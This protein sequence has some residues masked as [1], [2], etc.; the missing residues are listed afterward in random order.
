MTGEDP[1]AEYKN[2]PMVIRAL[3][4]KQLPIRPKEFAPHTLRGDERW[5]LLLDCWNLTP[6]L[7][8]R[9]SEVLDAVS[10]NFLSSGAE[11]VNENDS[12]LYVSDERTSLGL[13][14]VIQ[15]GIA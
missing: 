8:P 12:G 11:T 15:V 3:D 14:F 5:Q 4:R 2:T 6:S 9:C 7:R 10:V 1:Y 13:E